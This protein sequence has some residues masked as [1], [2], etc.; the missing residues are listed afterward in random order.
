MGNRFG[1]GYVRWGGGGDLV[2][3]AVRAGRR[4]LYLWRVVLTGCNFGWLVLHD[5]SLAVLLEQ[6]T[7]VCRMNGAGPWHA[8]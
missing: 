8:L 3:F 5:L 7:A 4:P 2:T 6:H 1:C